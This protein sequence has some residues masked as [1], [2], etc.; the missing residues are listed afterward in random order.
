[1]SVVIC[2]HGLRNSGGIERYLQTLVRGLHER[3][4]QPTVIAKKFDRTMPEYQWVTP[5]RLNVSW[6]PRKWRDFAFD[7]RLNRLK[8]QGLGGELIACNQTSAADIAICGSTHPGYLASMGQQ[9]GWLDRRK[10]E[11]ERQHLTRSR[12]VVAH[13]AFMQDQVVQYYG[14]DASKVKVIYPPVDTDKFHTVPDAERLQLRKSL[15]LPD[16]QMVFLLASTGHKRK[17]WPMLERFFSQTKLPI[18]LAVAGR[19]VSSQCDRIRYLGYRQD[20]ERVYRA[21]DATIMASSFEPF[22][23]VG[24][25]SVLS[26]TPVLLAR[27]VGCAEVIHE[28]AALAF[29]LDHRFS[30]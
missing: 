16:D 21:V 30:R 1:M 8:R 28:P 17:G 24:V 11:L 18:C 2:N 29:D 5:I 10:I 3:G 22:G 6:A 23:L 19:P 13:S 25:E 14:V 4:I 27:G 15:G 20:M 12:L 7:W 9:P 26:G